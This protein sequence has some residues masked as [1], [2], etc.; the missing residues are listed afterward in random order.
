MEPIDSLHLKVLVVDL[1]KDTVLIVT[2][3]SYDCLE[4]GVNV[5]EAEFVR[6]FD[7]G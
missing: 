2:S 4:R 7:L 6:V 1:A 5:H 3:L